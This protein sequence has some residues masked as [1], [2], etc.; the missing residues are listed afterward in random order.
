MWTAVFPPTSSSRLT[1][2]TSSR[3]HGHTR[4]VKKLAA[5]VHSRK[6]LVVFINNMAPVEG[7]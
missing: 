4:M 5:A 3:M 1:L 2:H 7:L 6:G